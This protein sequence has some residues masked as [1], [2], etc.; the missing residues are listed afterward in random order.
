MPAFPIS[1]AVSRLPALRWVPAPR[2]SPMAAAAVDELPRGELG[3]PELDQDPF[4]RLV[5][6]FLVEFDR[7]QTR[8]AYFND[9]RAWYAWC[10]DR[11]LHPL[12]ARRHD[13]S[14]WARELA[15]HP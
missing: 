15:E 11:D 13:V 7:R 1:T 9:L 5:A 8:R 4:W 10:A 2:R 6:A 12:A 14:R 3:D